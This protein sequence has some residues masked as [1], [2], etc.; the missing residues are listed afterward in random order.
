[1]AEVK[2]GDKVLSTNPEDGTLVFSEVVAFLDRN[3]HRAAAFYTVRT[4]SGHALTLTGKHLLYYLTQD[5][6]QRRSRGAG[7]VAQE[8]G[9]AGMREETKGNNLFSS[10]K[11]S[12]T[13]L[14]QA[15]EDSRLYS[16]GATQ[17]YKK[18]LPHG[19]LAYAEELEVGQYL[20]KVPPLTSLANVPKSAETWE[21]KYKSPPEEKR[22]ILLTPSRDTGTPQNQLTP[23]RI[24]SIETKTRKGV[25]APLTAKGTVVV[26]GYVTSC[27]AFLK[28]VNLAHNVMAPVRAYHVIKVQV[29]DWLDSVIK[30]AFGW[31]NFVDL[32]RTSMSSQS[33]PNSTLSSEVYSTEQDGAH[34]YARMLYS[35]A[36]N[37]L[38][39]DILISI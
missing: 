8:S 17:H 39:M 4:A 27:Y 2:V 28:D 25:F 13:S 7:L 20:L 37:V 31:L 18:E 26:D 22:E 1:M 33:H 10:F 21:N 12:N 15:I 23:D 36:V 34:W 24:V 29:N 5:D 32:S 38:H 3:P 14:R 35:I 9:V 11:A 30:P 19:R 6:V 16:E